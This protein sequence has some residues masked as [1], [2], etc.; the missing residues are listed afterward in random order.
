[1]IFLLQHSVPKIIYSSV[2]FFLLDNC[3]SVIQQKMWAQQLYTRTRMFLLML[4]LTAAT[5]DTTIHAWSST[6]TT[7]TTTSS[8]SSFSSRRAWLQK[9]AA[10]AVVLTTAPAAT[11]AAADCFQ[12]CLKNCRQI[13]PKDMAYCNQNCQDYC[14]QPDRTDGL[15]GSVSSASGEVGILGGAFGQGTVVKG[16]DKPPVINLP[17]LDFNSASGRKLLGL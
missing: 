13:A 4:L 1:M 14:D 9:T 2:D 3:H 8:S 15:S 7:T 6:R 11:W 16:E 17:G 10:V 5:F 12:D